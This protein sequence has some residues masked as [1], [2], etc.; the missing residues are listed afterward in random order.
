MFIIL[1]PFFIDFKFHLVDVV[2]FVSQL[3]PH[4]PTLDNCAEVMK[5]MMRLRRLEQ[6]RADSRTESS[7]CLA[8]S[9]QQ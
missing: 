9:A 6:S 7:R 4:V 1:S 2:D 3:W 8:A 5:G